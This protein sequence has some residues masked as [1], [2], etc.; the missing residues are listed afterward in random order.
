MKNCVGR[1]LAVLLTIFMFTPGLSIDSRGKSFI[2]AFPE[3]V[4]YYY[5]KS[6]NQLKITSLH[7]NT[8]VTVYM[9]EIKNVVISEPGKTWVLNFTKEFEEYRFTSS[10]WSVRITSDKNITVLSV[11]G[12]W[13]RFQSHVVQPDQNLGT[14]YQIPALNYS[15]LDSFS[16]SVMYSEARYISFRLIIINAVKERN[17]VTFKWSNEGGQNFENTTTLNAYNLFQLQSNGVKEIKATSK[18]AVLLT[19][20]CI[21]T[22]Q[23]CSCSM[24][25]NQLRP[26][27][28]TGNQYGKDR[29]FVPSTFDVQQLLLTTNQ[30]VKISNG[31][32]YSVEIKGPNSIDILPSFPNIR[33]GFINTINKPVSLQL[34]SSG[35]I[36]DLIPESMFAACYLVHFHPSG[37]GAFVIANKSD[38]DG[39]RMNDQQL[40]SAIKWNDMGGTESQYSLAVVNG[41]ESSTIWHPNATIAVYMIDRWDSDEKK[42]IHGGPAITINADPDPNGCVVTPKMYIVGTDEMSWTNSRQ[43]CFD[44][45][46]DFARLI[47]ADDQKKLV[48]DMTMGMTP[49]DLGEGWI[50][51][52]RDLLSTAWYWLNENNTSS[53]LNYTSWENGQPMKPYKGMCASV[54]L[55]TNN[56]FLWKAAHCCSRKKPVCF[57]ETRYLKQVSYL[58][59]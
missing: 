9:G 15:K 27:N 47:N 30:T 29:F 36:L 39:V 57:N 24:M 56:N 14:L 18:V 46:D 20:P 7:E 40:P 48:M 42:P 31:S 6:Y 19:H 45:A 1:M 58:T 33:K 13:G 3:N 21:D 16:S 43:Y 34:I 2:T 51:L 28:M 4:A 22:Q 11:T 53:N 8:N 52:R 55:D 10:N 37:S 44:K 5:R 35:L 32:E 59:K 49:R 50:S 12:W 25:L 38:Q 23:S 17:N 26:T 41:T 54:Y